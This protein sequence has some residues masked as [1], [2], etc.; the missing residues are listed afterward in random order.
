MIR[1]LKNKSV[2]QMKN[3]IWS[4]NKAIKKFF[5]NQPQILSVRVEIAET[6]LTAR[7]LC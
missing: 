5:A 4:G 6:E 7:T 2:T 1:I 3:D